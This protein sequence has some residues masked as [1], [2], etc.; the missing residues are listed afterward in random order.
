MRK[1]TDRPK[2]VHFS[3]KSVAAL[4]LSTALAACNHDDPSGTPGAPPPSDSSILSSFFV[5]SFAEF[6]DAA[7]QL[8]EQNQRYLLQ[9]GSW[10][11]DNNGNGQFDPA[12]EQTY[13]TSPLQSSGVYYAHA[14]G[15]TGNGQIIAITDNGFLSG[16]EAFAGKT[17]NEAGSLATEDHGT[18]VASVAAGDSATMIGMAPGADLVFG[19]FATFESLA[20]ATRLAEQLG[21]VAQNNSWGFVDT[22]VGQNSYNF[23]FSSSAGQD[24]LLSLRNYAEIGVVIFSISNEPGDT[25]ASLMPALPILEPGLEPGWLA[26]INGDA[27]MVGDDVVAARRLSAAC[28]EAAAWCLAAEGSWIGATATAVDSYEFSTGTSFAAPMVAGAM[29]ILAEAF[30]NLSPHDLRIRLLASAD[31]EFDGFN[32]TGTVELVEGFFHAISEEWGHGFLDVKAALLPIGTTTATLGDGTIYDIAEPLAV[33]GGATG[34]A[35][36]L[37]LS[38]VS[39]VVDDAL[40]AQFSVPADNLVAK[41]AERPLAEIL[42]NNWE[43]DGARSCCGLATYFPETRVV[44][45]STDV[46]TLSL[47]V[48]AGSTEDESY[49]VSLKRHFQSGIGELSV[50]LSLGR[51]GG[52][53]LPRWHSGAGGA[54]LAGGLELAAPL[55]AD[56]SIELGA[57]FGST[58]GETGGAGGSARLNSAS[59]AFV[60]RDILAGGDRL[61]VSVG[62]P[63]AVA[64]GQ[65]TLALPVATLGGTTEQRA[66]GIDLAP[67]NRE[68]RI[69][70]SYG[71]PLSARS[72]I[73]LT[74][75]HAD[76]FG[77]ITDRQNTGV[78]LGYRTEF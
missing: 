57:G 19:S 15:L 66:I 64:R 3:P 11:F 46:M 61:S 37:A 74:A 32:A 1:T 8:I 60:T 73:E 47:M 78:L 69:G 52:E 43:N 72:E 12:T 13:N 27:D 59:A 42:H 76:N 44:G 77:N 6:D 49:G 30:P 58:V 63:V 34:D 21:A 68:V 17:I 2:A 23:I 71:I 24:Y 16:H 53:L 75:A 10:F 31:N 54:I 4:L 62:M 18:L 35:V 39:L 50:N 38:G 25:Q 45:T 36:T 40:S 26:V 41:Q 70:L 56:I 29:A 51:D 5:E 48:P 20:E 7:R 33:E 28:L 22:P 67:V 9:E 65:T 55:G 14:A